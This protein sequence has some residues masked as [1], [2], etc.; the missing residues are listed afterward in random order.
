[1]VS[2]VLCNKCNTL[3]GSTGYARHYL[4]CDGKGPYR[5]RADKVQFKNL[6]TK[7]GD[8]TFQCPHCMKVGPYINIALH[9]STIVY[10][11]VSRKYTKGR[12]AWN[13]GLSK[14]TDSRIK[15]QGELSSKTL[16]AKNIVVSPET[17]KRISEKVKQFHKEN[18]GRLGGYRKNGGK[19]KRGRYKGY[20]CDSSWELAYLIF[21]LE[22][23]IPIQRN[24]EI[25]LYVKEGKTYKY[26][27]DFIV[28]GFYVE[29]KGW[30]MGNN[31][32]E[33]YEY[34]PH[35]EK[36]KLLMENEMKVYL[37]YTIDKYGPNFI[38]LYENKKPP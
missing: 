21:H 37:Q 14:H 35:K 1:M 36:F 24:K 32:K 30:D 27:P 28:D 26:T 6:L 38:S 2:K 11:R 12:V 16:K 18:P 25:F 23:G 33:K 8:D 5:Q 9:Y 17:R 31:M 22:H 13:K 19:G 29:I 7:I 3:I 15:Q 20:W 10:N 4:K 34:F